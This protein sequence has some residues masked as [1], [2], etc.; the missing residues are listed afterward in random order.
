MELSIVI[1]I[2]LYIVVIILIAHNI[3]AQI[4][5][6]KEYNKNKKRKE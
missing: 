1:M 3:T 5:D 4:K 6:I 2:I